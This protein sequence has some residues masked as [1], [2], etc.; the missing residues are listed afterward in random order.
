[1]PF[2]SNYLSCLTVPAKA[3][4]RNQRGAAFPEPL[5]A[6]LHQKGAFQNC[7]HIFGAIW[8]LCCDYG[9]IRVEFRCKLRGCI[10]IAPPADENTWHRG[11]LTP[12]QPAAAGLCR[13]PGRRRI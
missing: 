7:V 1:M 2:N 6:A 13:D 12:V 4:F 11:L 9:P 8:V 3:G 5:Q 10:I